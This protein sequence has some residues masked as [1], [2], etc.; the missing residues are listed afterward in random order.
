MGRKKKRSREQS[1]QQLQAIYDRLP[2]VNCKGKCLKGCS[3]I[4]MYPIELEGITDAGHEV[5]RASVNHV[6]GE[7]SCSALQQGRCSIYENRPLVCRLYGVAEGLT[8]LY[9]CQPDRLLSEAE[10]EEIRAA[11]GRLKKGEIMTNAGCTLREAAAI[12][13]GAM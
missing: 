4:G 1:L 7:I 2:Q 11:V 5:P 6:A 8:C 10:A 12:L 13:E 9:G 3:I